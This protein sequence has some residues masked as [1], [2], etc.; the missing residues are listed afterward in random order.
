MG[1]APM[2][3]EQ[4]FE[5][6]RRINAKGVTILLVEQNAPMALGIA[7]RGRLGAAGSCWMGRGANCWMM[8]GEAGVSR[9]TEGV[10]VS[11]RSGGEL[12][13]GAGIHRLVWGGGTV[14]F[15][16]VDRLRWATSSEAG[17]RSL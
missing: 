17:A 15:T 2:L 4:V 16:D 3:V 7:D 6:I 13:D 1:L 12:S 11:S 10:G 14:V 9:L 8:K 5:T